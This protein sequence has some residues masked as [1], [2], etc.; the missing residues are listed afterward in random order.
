MLSP[1]SRLSLSEKER[2]VL[3]C[4]RLHPVDVANKPKPGHQPE[5]LFQGRQ[6]AQVLDSCF[7]DMVAVLPIKLELLQERLNESVNAAQRTIIVAL[8]GVW[9]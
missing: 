1:R 4:A 7:E 2:E 9:L 8:V 6:F 3:D 5:L